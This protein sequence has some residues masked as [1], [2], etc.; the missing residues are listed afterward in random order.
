MPFKTGKQLQPGEVLNAAIGIYIE[1]G[2]EAYKPISLS[3]D[4]GGQTIGY[5]FRK[6]GVIHCFSVGKD[7]EIENEA[8]PL[9]RAVSSAKRLIKNDENFSLMNQIM[10]RF[11]S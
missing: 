2:W 6:D 11:F 3:E 10:Q 1:N 9:S 7:N 4:L 5:F 8:T